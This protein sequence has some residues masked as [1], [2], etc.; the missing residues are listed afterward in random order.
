[1]NKQQQFH[2]WYF[3]VGFILLLLFQSWW[4]SAT[5]TERIAY[6]RFLELLE[7]GQIATVQVTSEQLTGSYREPLDGRTHFVTN[8]VP[9][10][11]ADALARNKVEFDG[12]VENTFIGALLSW[13]IPVLLI[14]GLWSFLFRGMA[15]R[16]GLGGMM[17]VGKSKAKVYVEKDTGVTFED[18]AGVDEAKAELKEIVDF[19]KQ[20]EKF[21][22]LGA[23][24]P[25]GILLTGPP[26]TGKT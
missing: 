13:V 3:L 21:G 25:K 7:G 24:I 6:S 4:S 14:F 16:Q 10:D 5:V 17:N 11:L 2:V 8:F 18:V 15:E 23:R 9:K 26:G 1:M 20:P 12:T 19:L 22:R